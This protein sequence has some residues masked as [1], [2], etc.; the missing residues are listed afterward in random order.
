MWSVLCLCAVALAG[1]IEGSGASEA[2]VRD[3][4]KILQ[5]ELHECR[6]RSDR[7]AEREKLLQQH[8]VEAREM[9]NM[10]VADTE[11]RLAAKNCESV[12]SFADGLISGM[13]RH[14]FK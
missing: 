2:S 1:S 4:M 9:Q 13:R 12:Q 14:V 10:S 6:V 11:T 3:A 5:S 8:L 7:L